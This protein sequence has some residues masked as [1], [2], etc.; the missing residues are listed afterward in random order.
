MRT[1][2]KCLNKNVWKSSRSSLQTKKSF[3]GAVKMTA[4]RCQI[5]MWHLLC[6]WLEIGWD[7]TTETTRNISNQDSRSFLDDA[8]Q[9]S[10]WQIT[11]RKQLSLN[12]ILISIRNIR[13]FIVIW[14]QMQNRFLGYVY[15][16]DDSCQSH[17]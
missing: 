16:I 7:L 1:C 8:W 3:Q 9:L 6:I 14:Y 4:D 11:T 13:D 5:D 12:S 2:R 15:F 17:N 10:K